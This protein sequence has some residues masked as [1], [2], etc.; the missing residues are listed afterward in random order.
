MRHRPGVPQVSARPSSHGHGSGVS[1][2]ERGA[3]QSGGV[4]GSCSYS[5]PLRAYRSELPHRFGYGVDTVIR[6]TVVL[7]AQNQE[8][9]SLSAAFRNASSESIPSCGKSVATFCQ[10]ISL[11]PANSAIWW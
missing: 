11:R 10:S 3:V 7:R 9:P 5:H 6:R 2:P 8:T 1:S 4:D